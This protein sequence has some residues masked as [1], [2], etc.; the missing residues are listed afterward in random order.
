MSTTDSRARPGPAA[1]HDDDDDV[2][3]TRDVRSY[4]RCPARRRHRARPSTLKAILISRAAAVESTGR[5]C[6]GWLSAH[7]QCAAAATEHATR[8][9]TGGDPPEAGIRTTAV[10]PHSR[11]GLRGAINITSGSHRPSVAPPSGLS[12]NEL[13]VWCQL[14]ELLRP[15]LYRNRG[16][17][18]L[19]GFWR[20][21]LNANEGTS[22]S[23]NYAS[24]KVQHSRRIRR[25]WVVFTADVILSS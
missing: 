13:P 9:Q 3:W 1:T 18:A 23:G 10:P 5:D 17:P 12:T 24:D 2:C 19:S 8:K 21:L 16:P 6:N 15:V 25:R 22:L 11:T 20:T 14:E 7:A 4:A